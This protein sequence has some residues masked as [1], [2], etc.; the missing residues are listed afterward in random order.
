MRLHTLS[1]FYQLTSI[2]MK[3]SN[4]KI[5]FK[6]VKGYKRKDY[7]DGDAAIAWEK[8]KNKY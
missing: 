2:D 4:G 5:A 8:V 6:I 1:S 7:P 3:T